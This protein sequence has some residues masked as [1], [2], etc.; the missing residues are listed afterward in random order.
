MG[1]SGGVFTRARDWTADEGAALNIEA[2]LMDQEDDNFET[3]IN[4]CLTKDGQNSP[5]TDLPMGGNRHTGVGNANARTTYA[6]A[7]DVMDQDLIYYVDSG[8]ADAYVITPSPAYTAYEEGMRI[9]FRAAN[10]NTGASTMNVNSLGAIAIQN[11]DASALSAG[12]IVSGGI[13]ELTYDANTTPDRWV[14][15]SPPALVPATMLPATVEAIAGLAVTDS[16]IIVGNGS[17]WVAESGSTARTSLGLG[18]IATQAA[19]SVSITG[20]SITGITDLA[21]ADGGTGSSTAAD[22]RTALGV[23]IGSNV[24]AYSANLAAIAAL[25]VTDS[26]VIVGN[27]STWVAESGATARTSLGL[28]SLATLSTINNSNWSGTDLAVANGGTGASDAATARSNLGAPGTSLSD[29]DFSGITNMLGSALV[30]TDNMLVMDGAAARRIAYSDAGIPV[31][32][33]TG[34]T[35]TLATA[36]MNTFIEYTNAS[37]VAVTLNTGVGAVGN[38]VLIKQTGAGQV[39]VSGT[40]TIEAANGA[41]TANQDSVIALVCIAANTWAL[42]G[43]ASA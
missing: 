36:D 8:A 19:S 17:T 14:M 18:T 27:G 28:G 26:N 21:V 29:V 4:N 40:A 43:D 13:Y 5:T 12:E 3:G 34:T 22:A 16:N 7:A 10:A 23:A 41:S 1:W 39:T 35:D 42:F 33:V 11:A 32:T 37:A 20:G 6:S 24:Q 38:V 2:S 25:A 30:S 15:T 9:V 31:Q